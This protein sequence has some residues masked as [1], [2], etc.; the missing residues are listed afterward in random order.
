[1]QLLVTCLVDRFFPDTGDAVVA[2]LERL[3]VA[4]EFPDGQ[5]CCG[6][7]AFNAGFADEARA[8]A[9]HTIDVLSASDAPV[10]V[11]SGSCGDMVIHQYAE[12]FAND[13]VY[14]ARAKALAAR[15]FEFTQFLV[16]VLGV[17]RCR[18]RAPRG[19]VAYH[20]CCH[21]L[22]G[23]GVDD[24][25]EALLAG[26]ARHRRLPAAEA[27]VCCGFGGLFAV[28][29]ADISGAMLAR[30]LDRIEASGADTVV[31][32]DVSCAHAHER[33]PAPA[34]QPRAGAPPRR[35][36]RR[37]G[38]PMSGRVP[39]PST[40]GSR[41]RW[42]DD[43]RPARGPAH[44]AQGPR[45][46]VAAPRLASLEGADALRDH[47]RAIRAHTLAQLDRYLDQFVDGRRGARA[48]TSTTRRPATTR[49]A[50]SAI[51]RSDAAC[52]LAVKSKS[53]VSEEIELNHA[54]EAA[55]I[56]VVE[57]DLGEYVVQLAHDRPSHIVAPIM[58]KTKE[59]V[60]RS[61][62][63]SSARPTRT[64]PTCRT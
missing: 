36:A 8:L 47:A 6:Q 26:V 30:K 52:E 33:R 11:P 48:A 63:R 29:M 59:D 46:E 13:P 17:T 49:S 35:S 28:K 43:T 10:V 18:R 2:V 25:P 16:D 40:G 19:K 60:A 32:T 31:V 21:G 64:S 7:P 53:M 15:T 5:T 55:G 27:D 14:A 41:R 38:R 1:M 24:Q 34:R 61:S 39:S 20:A 56:E 9:R 58:H 42:P 54:L 22:R 3:G 62:A 45:H 4:V 57:T 51:S 23:L 50:T 37:H 12:L 44:R